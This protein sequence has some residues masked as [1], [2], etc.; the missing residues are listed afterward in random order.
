MNT[1]KSDTLIPV[2]NIGIPYWMKHADTATVMDAL[3][4]DAPEGD[5][6]A[7]FVGGCVRN[8]LLD[9]PVD[10]IDIATKLSPEEV[11][12]R[13]QESGLKVIPN[14]VEHGT[15]T[16]VGQER[17]FE[18]TTLRRDVSTDGRRAT[19]A[20]SE[21]WVEDARR[22]D[23]TLN[24]LLVDT[25][26][27][28]FDPLGEGLRALDARR[29]V[30][31]G[32]VAR[33][34]EEDRLR[35]LRFF[36]FHAIYGQGEPDKAALAACRE[37][38]AHVYDL[39]RERIT[40]EVFKILSVDNPAEILSIMFRNKILTSLASSEYEPDELSAL[41][42]HQ[43]RYG[44]AFIASRLLGLAGWQMESANQMQE[45]L[46]IPNV[47]L[48]DMQ[49]IAEVLALPDLTQDHA[50]KVAV[51]KFGRIAT[52]Q[53]LMIE[54][55]QD[56]VVNAHV[57]S[58]IKIIQEWD[59]PDLPVSGQDLLVAGMEAGPALGEKLAEI[60]AFWISK[61]FRACK[62]DCMALLDV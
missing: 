48:K 18:I 39:S 49:A 10:D 37:Q 25:Q 43:N 35:I 36:R 19:V 52:A 26:G 24:T 17:S 30:F 29:V 2:R 7:L 56:R 58:G 44:L 3:N 40:Q 22:R 12:R 55:A 1:N 14:G 11:T 9:F 28:V 46:L 13:M 61:N 45:F 6:Q 51:Y 62:E 59:I 42:Y 38:A 5:P 21:D 32:D 54:L 23:F 15:V 20:F 27:Q 4:R 16:V 34:I 8:A 47:F 31:V 41:C 33:R 57:P 50:L 60:E 53:A